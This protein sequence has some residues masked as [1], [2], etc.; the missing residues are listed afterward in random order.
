MSLDSEVDINL[1][2]S[3]NFTLYVIV[4][5]LS[6]S[7]LIDIEKVISFLYF[8]LSILADHQILLQAV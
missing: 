4:L 8:L 1:K 7:F 6:S 5:L 3:I 2:V